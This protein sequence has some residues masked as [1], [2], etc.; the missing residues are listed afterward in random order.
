MTDEER[1][2]AR[3]YYEPINDYLEVIS[4]AKKE[5]QYIDVAPKP[6]IVQVPLVE[7][8]E[9]VK[10]LKADKWQKDFC[11]RLQ[12]AAVNR[13][14][15]PTLAITH[16]EAQI[17]KSILQAQLYNSWLLGHDPTH[18]IV[19]GTYNVGKSEDHSIVVIQTMQSA[20]HKDI[21]QNRD[22]WIPDGRIN[23]S[24][25][26]TFGRMDINDGQYSFRAVGL[27]SGITGS[28]FNT[29]IIDDPY[30]NVRDAF[31]DTIRKNLQNFW[32]NDI[33]SR[34][35]RFS[36]VFAMFHRYHVEDLAGYLLAT[37]Y[38]DYWR[39]ATI[40]DGDYKDAKTGKRYADPIGR[41]IGEYISPERR[42]P[43]Y[44]AKTR[45]NKRVWRSMFQGR[46]SA[47]EGDFFNIG[48]IQMIAS[49]LA[50]QRRS[51]CAVLVRAWDLA[52]TEAG[53]DYS[54][55]V[56][57]GMRPD[58]KVTIFDIKR[59][60]VDTAGRDALQLRTA[61]EDGSDVII[62]VPRDPGT[63][64]SVVFYI[65]QKLKDF[66]VVARSTSGSKEDRARNF[67]SCVNSGDCEM[68]LD[69]NL[70]EEKQWNEPA[71]TEMRDFPLSDNDDIIDAEAD[72]YNEAYE[73]MVKGKVIHAYAPQRN[74]L[75]YA[76]FA[77][78]LPY[79]R[80]EKLL[81][82]IPQNFRI[83]IGLKISADASLP[84]CGI[85]TARAA[86]NANLG[87]K[88]FAVSEYKAY[89]GN[90]QNLINW[91]ANALE[92][93]CLTANTQNTSIWLHPDSAHFEQTLIEKFAVNVATFDG[94]GLAGITETNWYLG[95]D[96]FSFLI[97]GEQFAQADPNKSTGFYHARQE[98][99]TWG[100]GERGEPNKIAAVM[101][102]LRMCVASYATHAEPLTQREK[103]S[104]KLM[105]R[106]PEP[107]RNKSAEEIAQMPVTPEMSPQLTL[108][109][110]EEM[111]RQEL[112]KKGDYA[113][114]SPFD[115]SEP[116]SEDDLSNGW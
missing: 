87:E 34:L 93:Y 19:L 54:V 22:G 33:S 65:Q 95:S 18:R 74:L 103:Y 59:E 42:P 70:P 111:L 8:F 26:S 66:T 10:R 47:E 44:Y 83:Y 31:S 55:G 29:V 23:R 100:F 71:K 1:K 40:C 67:S 16:A 62:T 4:P 77:Q 97:D 92:I 99:A 102:C 32:D 53:G 17:G 11:Q 30:A 43:E 114:S 5:I 107:L 73:R 56:L 27:Q 105:E 45:K 68:A 14:I 113:P 60:Q 24:K 88:I 86:E 84:T 41:R 94:D 101:D 104:R 112:R 78:K 9:R 64:K 108:Q 58:G 7:Y 15:K 116:D 20:I 106:L 38:F 57:G 39:Y 25:W 52:A 28:G 6:L 13:H 36:N 63:G 76:A 21:F 89:D 69:D 96:K 2:A 35:D 37:G 82:K 48:K 50:A 75:T 12:D 81:L 115:S 3:A 91:L 110:T 80:D 46:P 61:Q 49:E 51:E 79:R 85:I 72:M 90:Y 109:M 98:I